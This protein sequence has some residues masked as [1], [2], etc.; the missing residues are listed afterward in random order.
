MRNKAQDARNVS[1]HVIISAVTYTGGTGN[2]IKR[3]QDNVAL[4]AGVHTI[5]HTVSTVLPVVL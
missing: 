2:T 3:G 5:S 4:R 1:V